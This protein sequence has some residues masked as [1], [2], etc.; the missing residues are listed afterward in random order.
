ML[1]AL[2]LI[3]FLLV[4]FAGGIYTHD[5]QWFFVF[6]KSYLFNFFVF[7]FALV[8]NYDKDTLNLF[9]FSSLFSSFI[10]VF[11][12]VFLNQSSFWVTGRYTIDLFGSNLDQ[13]WFA[14]ILLLGC[15]NGI[16]VLGYKKSTLYKV[17]IFSFISFITIGIVLTGSRTFLLAFAF[18]IILYSLYSIIVKRNIALGLVSL[19]LILGFVLIYFL[20]PDNLKGRFALSKL[21]AFDEPGGRF[22]I[23]SHIFPALKGHI[24]FGYGSGS[25]SLITIKFYGT[26]RPIHNDFYS[27]LLTNG[28]IGLISYSF[29]HVSN[30]F[31]SFKSKNYLPILLSGILFI[32]CLFLDTPQAKFFWV[33]ILFIYYFSDFKYPKYYEVKI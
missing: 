17:F 31:I 20:I 1:F 27:F 8:I 28:I 3:I 4:F 9:S 13:N 10:A 15:V 30:F 2:P 6:S 23:W 18:V 29:I 22:D 33:Y 5:K 19:G 26:S 14:I 12:A 32:Y 25:W 7:G 21:L 16:K 24:F 11:I